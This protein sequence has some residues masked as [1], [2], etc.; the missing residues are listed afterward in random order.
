M[1]GKRGRNQG[2]GDKESARR[3]NK[4]QQRFVESEE[5]QEEIERVA[6]DDELGD[7]FDEAEREAAGRAKEHDPSVSRD[8]RRPPS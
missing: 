7:E 8:Y 6:G 2:E 3:F 4:S 5:G 1:E